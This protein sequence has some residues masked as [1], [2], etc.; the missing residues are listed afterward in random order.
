VGAEDAGAGPPTA[1]V[2]VDGVTLFRVRG[3]TAYPAEQRAS[4]IAGRIT[5]LAADRSISLDSLSLS[6]SPDATLLLAGTTRVLGVM[7]ADARLEAA[8]RQT[9]AA[10]L[11]ARVRAAVVAYRHDREPRVLAMAAVRAVAALLVLAV[12]LVAVR[13]VYRR[14]RS[15]IES[16]YRPRLRDLGIRSFQIVRGEQLWRAATGI[17]SAAWA[18]FVLSAVYACLHY[19][20]VLFPWTRGLGASLFA[21]VA[22]PLQF[23]AEGALAIVPKLVFL[24]ILVVVTRYL[25]RLI[26]LFFDAVATGAV[27][28]H[29][30]DADWA[31]PTY[32]LVR[33][34]VIAFAVVVAYPYV[35]GS[36]TDAFKGV[37]VF[38]GLVFSLGSSSF[39]GNLIAGYSMTYRRAFRVGDVIGVGSHV[40]IVESIR[41]MV[42]RLRT[43]KGEDVVLPNSRILNDDVVNY[44]TLARRGELI[45]HTTVGIG[46]ETPWRQVEGMLLEATARTEDA[47]RD[48]RPFVLQTALG[49]FAVTYELNVHCNAPERMPRI[50]AR[51]HQN[52]LDVFNEYGVQIMTPAYE[53][54]PKQPK[55]VPPSQFYQPPAV[56]EGV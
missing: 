46:Y 1:P 48:P 20:L 27:T 52:I 40:G 18:V 41:L 51:L 55:V 56:K 39:I 11:L 4:D 33:I 21:M 16:R 38:I 24:T 22:V 10:A 35:P 26:R 6:E 36:Q 34:L 7:D 12:G 50:Y 47:L 45:L 30:F 19:V 43:P 42:T 5:A 17:L 37:S 31:G 28:F 3:I 25:L 32:R 8:R 2:V 15:G 44:S 23:L 53:A 14:L 13:W 9:L 49:D 29:S 54:D